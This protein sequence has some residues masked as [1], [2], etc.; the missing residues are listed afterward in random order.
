MD[1]QTLENLLKECGVSLY[2][3]ETVTENDHRIYRIYITS[4]EPVTL[5]K[6]TEVTRIISPIMDLN[7]PVEGEYF[8]EVSSPGIDRQLKTIDHFRHSTGE[9]VKLKL[10]D[11]TKLKA[12]ILGTE[13]NNIKVYD[14][15]DKTEKEIPF[16]EIAKAKT[17]FEW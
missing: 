5:E 14:K 8:L 9:L 11:G 17:Y 7:P 15:Q 2:D 16:S 3:T 13:G 10:E 12:K 4:D 6:C 1:K